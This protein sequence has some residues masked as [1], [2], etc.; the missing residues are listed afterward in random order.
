[1]N[2]IQTRRIAALLTVLVDVLF[3]ANID[4]LFQPFYQGLFLVIA[5]GGSSLLGRALVMRR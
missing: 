3:F 2:A 5:V 4:P 1:M